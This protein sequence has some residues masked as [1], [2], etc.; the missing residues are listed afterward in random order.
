MRVRTLMRLGRRVKTYRDDCTALTTF[1]DQ[2]HVSPN[3]MRLSAH[4]NAPCR[5]LVRPF[6]ERLQQSFAQLRI[7]D[8]NP[9]LT[10][11]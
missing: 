3:D 7:K 2:G 1:K 4:S 11:T 6:R 8:V 9:S 10:S 5:N